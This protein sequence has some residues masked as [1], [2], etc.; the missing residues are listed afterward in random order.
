MCLRP[1]SS[2]LVIFYSSNAGG[3]GFTTNAAAFVGGNCRSTP[4]LYGTCPLMRSILIRAKLQI[5]VIKVILWHVLQADR[6][7]AT[8]LVTS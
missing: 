8:Q 3:S 4:V 1:S 6:Y 5:E 7:A 2:A